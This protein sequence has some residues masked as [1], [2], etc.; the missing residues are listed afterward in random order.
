MTTS[1]N[2]NNEPE[3]LTIKTRDNEIKNLYYQTEKYDLENIIKSLKTD[4]EY[5]K[6]K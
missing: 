3:L 4:N 1:A 5:Y 6:K 2:L